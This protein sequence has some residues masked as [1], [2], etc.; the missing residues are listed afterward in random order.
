MS[1][2]DRHQGINNLAVVRQVDPGEGLASLPHRIKGQHPV[3]GVLKMRDHRPPK[4]AV[5][6]GDCD[7]H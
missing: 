7:L 4:F 5:A 6:T 3:P 2:I 1:V